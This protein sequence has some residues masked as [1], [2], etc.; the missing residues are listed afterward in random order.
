MY[1]SNG[2]YNNS[3]AEA[4]ILMAITVHGPSPPVSGTHYHRQRAPTIIVPTRPRFRIRQLLTYVLVATHPV[5]LYNSWVNE[6]WYKV[7]TPKL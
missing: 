2:R 3:S 7:F 1:L 4:G 5:G 6:I